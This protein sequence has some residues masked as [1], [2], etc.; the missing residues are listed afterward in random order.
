MLLPLTT[1][2]TETTILN[3]KLPAIFD[4]KR[5]ELAQRW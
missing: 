2:R 4:Y 3:I 5:N 1:V